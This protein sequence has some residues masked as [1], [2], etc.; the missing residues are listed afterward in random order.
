VALFAA[1]SG[2]VSVTWWHAGLLVPL[3]IC[4][5]WITWSPPGTGTREMETAGRVALAVLVVTQTLWSGYALFYDHYHA[6]SPD[7]AAAKF[8]SPFVRNHAS[9]AVTYISGVDDERVRAYPAV[10]ILPYFDHNIFAN[11]P[12]PFWW[13]SDQDPSE[14]RFNALL[15]SHPQIVLV[16]ET[17]QHPLESVNLDKPKYVTL[18]K[19]GYRFVNSFCGSQPRQL[20]AGETLCHVV[21][22]Y[23]GQ[24]DSASARKPGQPE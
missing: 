2:E 11:I 6:Y 4:L 13:W 19:D 8:L 5:L 3:L 23:A 16:E 10:G 7:P 15:P 20:E 21:F 24:P 22:E 9:I 18:A 14:D 12:Y 17:H 1:F